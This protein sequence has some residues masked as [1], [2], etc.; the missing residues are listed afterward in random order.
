[1]RRNSKRGTFARVYISML[2]REIE[3]CGGFDNQSRAALYGRGAFDGQPRA[4]IYAEIVAHLTSRASARCD[5]RRLDVRKS[6]L[7]LEQATDIMAE[8]EA[9]LVIDGLRDR[10]LLAAVASTHHEPTTARERLETCHG[11]L[12]THRKEQGVEGNRDELSVDECAKCG[13]DFLS[14]TRSEV[15]NR[16]RELPMKSDDDGTC[17]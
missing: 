8:V 13:W 5:A 14:V 4:A 6:E 2:T 17:S 7:E 9:M 12:E 16:C 15:C 10:D 1:M 3:R 11:T